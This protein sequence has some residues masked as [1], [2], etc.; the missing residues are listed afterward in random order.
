[1]QVHKSEGKL[2]TKLEQ[3]V[4]SADCAERSYGDTDRLNGLDHVPFIGFGYVGLMWASYMD[5][6]LVWIGCAWFN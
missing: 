4:E 5:L 2:D 1:M 3:V 6:H